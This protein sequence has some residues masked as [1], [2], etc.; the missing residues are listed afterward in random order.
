MRVKPELILAQTPALTCFTPK[1]RRPCASPWS[2]IFDFDKRN[3]FYSDYVH[4]L[5]KVR[6][7]S[8]E[9]MKVAA[10]WLRKAVRRMSKC[11]NVA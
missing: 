5:G 7:Y 11:V 10:A 4:M 9:V 2:V 8:P 3:N 1:T 6:V